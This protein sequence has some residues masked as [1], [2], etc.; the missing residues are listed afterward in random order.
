[1]SSSSSG[2]SGSMFVPKSTSGRW[3][4]LVL[5]LWLIWMMINHPSDAIALLQAIGGAIVDLFSTM[6]EAYVNSR[7][8]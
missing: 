7:G 5:V 6:Y 3:V 4:M 8:Q 1:M 2:R